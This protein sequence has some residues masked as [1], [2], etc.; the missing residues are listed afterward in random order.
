M[1]IGDYLTVTIN[2]AGQYTFSSTETED[3]LTVT[4]DNDV[5]IKAGTQPLT[6][7]ITSMGD[8][9]V[10]IAVNNVCDT[11]SSSRDILGEYAGQLPG[12]ISTVQIGFGEDVANNSLYFTVYRFNATSTNNSNRSFAIYEESELA[13]EGI[14]PGTVIY[15]LSFEKLL[16]S[17]HRTWCP[18]VSMVFAPIRAFRSHR[19]KFSLIALSK[20]SGTS[21]AHPA[22]PEGQ[23]IHD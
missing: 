12:G 10:H 20:K 8:Y 18:V 16:S 23:F 13:A 19:I 3:F 15:S 5:I 22:A 11:Q 21:H 2:D 7:P 6:V 1:F 17:A 4:D 14:T 9:R